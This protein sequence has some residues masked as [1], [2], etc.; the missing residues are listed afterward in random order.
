M[1]KEGEAIP[2]SD[3]RKPNRSDER[4]RIENSGGFVM[5]A[6]VLAMSSPFGNRLLKQCLVAEPEIR[7]EVVDEHLSCWFLQAMGCG[8]MSTWELLVLASN[9]WADAMFLARVEE[10]PEA[11]GS[12]VD[13]DITCQVVR[14]HHKKLD[15]DSIMCQRELTI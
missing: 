9:E 3:D 10:E 12:V 7:E 4:K 14:F 1:S 6:V 11:V 2:L 5:W 8:L 15:A 13:I